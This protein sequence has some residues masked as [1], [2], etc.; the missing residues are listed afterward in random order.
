ML[1]TYTYISHQME[2]MQ[3]FIDFIFFEVWCKAPGNGNFSLDLLNGSPEL[4]EVMEAFH[5]SDSK[6]ADFFNSHVERIYG[7]FVP[8]TP[9]E[10]DKFKQW[11]QANNDIEKV[12]AN[13]PSVH[14][15]RY[16]DI[17]A[18]YPDLSKQL[19]SFFKGLYSDKLLGLKALRE[20][21]GQ[22][23]DHYDNFM[24]RNKEGKCLFCG[25]SDMLGVYHTKREAYDHY[26]PKGL[27]PFNSINFRNLVPACHH[28]NSSYKLEKDPFFTL[29]D[30]LGKRCRRKAF[31]PY[32]VPVYRIEITVDLGKS[33]IENLEPSDIQLTFGPSAISEEIETW[34]DVY[35][36]EERYKA[37][38]CNENGGK[39]W[40][41]EVRIACHNYQ[42]KPDNV[43]ATVRQVSENNPVADSNFLKVAFLEE[44][45]RIGIWN[46]A[47]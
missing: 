40:V 3:E 4:K 38:C 47:S 43:L 24:G 19:A 26:L 46:N 12:C 25:I 36:I 5:Y 31:Y 18:T 14:I 17:E 27:Y 35:G 32:S 42:T 30:P 11:Y 44:C 22:I 10:I 33:D 34:K 28:C 21:I 39:Y 8:L 41:E 23:D 2:K 16:A 7:L 6:W 29:K 1:F 13:D 9:V 45:Y 37:K 20:K 15:A